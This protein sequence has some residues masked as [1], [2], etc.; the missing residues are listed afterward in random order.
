MHT[1]SDVV[2]SFLCNYLKQT[3]STRQLTK[4][5]MAA[6]LRIDFRSYPNLETGR[7]CLSATS[8]LFLLSGLEDQEVLDLLCRFRLIVTAGM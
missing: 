4:T 1:Y 3:R 5:A 6:W 7:Y 8:L 2:K